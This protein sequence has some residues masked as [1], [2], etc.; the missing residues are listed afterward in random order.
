[1]PGNTLTVTPDLPYQSLH[2]L[3]TGFFARFEGAQ[4]SAEL[5]KSVSLVDTP[6]VLS[7][8]KQRIHRAYDFVQVRVF[9]SI[10]F[11]CD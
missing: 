9:V 6:G 7:G 8:E 3:G 11:Q 1:M 4:C 5:L 10:P 2:H